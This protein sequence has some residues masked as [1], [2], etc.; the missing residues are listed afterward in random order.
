VSR[1]GG[2]VR[3]VLETRH[4]RVTAAPRRTGISSEVLAHDRRALRDPGP[5]RMPGQ[6]RVQFG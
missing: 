2:R 3:A 5:A 6:N 4:D 1:R